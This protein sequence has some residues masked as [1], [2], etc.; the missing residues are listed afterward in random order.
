MER[1]NKGCEYGFSDLHLLWLNN[2]TNTLQNPENY[3]LTQTEGE[4]RQVF[5][6]GYYNGLPEYNNNIDTFNYNVKRQVGKILNCLCLEQGT[7]LKGRC[8]GIGTGNSL[9]LN[10][11]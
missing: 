1:E 9:F 7:G 10:D 6:Y 2:S 3:P 5:G 8:I 4:C 11:F